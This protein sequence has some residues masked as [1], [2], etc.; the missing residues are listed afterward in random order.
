MGASKR[1]QRFFPLTLLNTLLAFA[2]LFGGAEADLEEQI[3]G[4]GA[5]FEPGTTLYF[6]KRRIGPFQITQTSVSHTHTHRRTGEY[7]IQARINKVDASTKKR[8]G[9]K[10]RR[11]VDIE[12][13]RKLSGGVAGGS[14]WQ[15]LRDQRN[16]TE[17]V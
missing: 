9:R 5:E 13:C 7:I 17:L 16:P 4:I 2:L 14:G 3:L 15:I 12:T 1:L 6:G 8:R 10:K 11:G